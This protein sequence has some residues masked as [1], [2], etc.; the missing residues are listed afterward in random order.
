MKPS[1]HACCRLQERWAQS[2]LDEALSPAEQ[3]LYEGHLEQC[4][5]CRAAVTVFRHLFTAL[6]SDEPPAIP[7][8]L[9][10]LQEQWLTDYLKSGNSTL[11]PGTL[12]KL[13]K[14]IARNTTR[15]VQWLPGLSLGAK[16][17]EKTTRFMVN[18]IK[19][20]TGRFLRQK[21]KA[22]LAR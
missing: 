18:Q 5:H 14:H 11:T 22:L 3:L 15:Y 7:P 6:S 17:T 20:K 8:A 2:Y 12:L 19:Q 4:P 9:M 21:G 1:P 16:I 10:L 13:Q